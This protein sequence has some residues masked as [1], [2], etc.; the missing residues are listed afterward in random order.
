V[1]SSAGK[2][3]NTW[4][5]YRGDSFQIEVKNPADALRVAIQIKAA[6]KTVKTLDVRMA[7]GI[8]N[9]AYNGSSVIESDGE[10]FVR[11]GQTFENLGKLKQTLAISSGWPEFDRDMNVFLR[12]A[13]I[14]M[15]EWSTS[16]AELVL[17][18]LNEKELTQE[19]VAKKLGVSQPAV[20]ERQNRSHFDEI[21]ELERL[22]REKIT[23]LT[24][25]K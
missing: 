8:G 9:K 13:C 25:T 4:Q 14:P 11:S 3:P 23:S 22:Y 5:I 21:T 12:L 2:S 24:S 20:S 15:D 6:I 10:A 1:L 17:L 18:L 16:S 7:I 19:E